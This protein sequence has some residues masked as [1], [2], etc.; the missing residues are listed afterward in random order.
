MKN[1]II[2]GSPR[3]GKTTLADILK[4]QYPY[5]NVLH[6]DVIRNVL[7]ENIPHEQL[8]KITHDDECYCKFMVGYI[9]ASTKSSKYPFIID[10]SR[11]Y[12]EY[13]RQLEGNRENVVI[14]LTLGDIC[15]TDLY[16]MCRKY[17]GADEFTY[18]ESYEKLMK[19]CERWADIN[20]KII[21]KSR[22]ILDCF[23]TYQDREAV[24]RNILLEIAKNIV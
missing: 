23:N 16:A 6:C 1:I 10:W 15:A 19:H 3:S 14:C 22:D 20:K 24:F 8:Q 12:P 21:E 17:D 18:H 5:Y 4:N 11:L 9:N 13:L 7:A 2:T